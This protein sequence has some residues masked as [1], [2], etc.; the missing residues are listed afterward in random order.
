M[1]FE[2]TADVISLKEPQQLIIFEN[3]QLPARYK[4]DSVVGIV[5]D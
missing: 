4:I 5:I 1:R 2:F 3:H